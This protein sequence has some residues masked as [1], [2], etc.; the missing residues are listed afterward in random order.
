MILNPAGIV[1]GSGKVGSMRPEEVFP[2][3]ALQGFKPRAEELSEFLARHPGHLEALGARLE[4]Q[5]RRGFLELP[6]RPDQPRGE[7]Y[8]PH[9]EAFAQTLAALSEQPAWLDLPRVPMLLR[10][11]F[12]QRPRDGEAAS[13]VLLANLR[14]V[15]DR[16]RRSLVLDPNRKNLWRCWASIAAWNQWGD[17]E[18]L[19][20]GI[21]PCPGAMDPPIPHDSL[22][23]MLKEDRRWGIIET[24]AVQAFQRPEDSGHAEQ[25]HE[26]RE[27]LLRLVPPLFLSFRK[28]GRWE[29]LN[30]WIPLVRA[31]AGAHWGELR[32]ALPSGLR[33]PFE[34][35]VPLSV[36]AALDQPP[37]TL[38]PG[39]P[40]NEAPLEILFGE[41][42]WK[43]AMA[44]WA[45]PPLVYLKPGVVNWKRTQALPSFWILRDPG[46]PEVSFQGMDHPLEGLTKE[47]L[48]R[49]PPKVLAWKGFLKSHPGHRE[50]GRALYAALSARLPNPFLS[51][52]I[53]ALAADQE[54]PPP[55][56]EMIPEAP[57]I[58]TTARGQLAKLDSR[59]RLNPGGTAIWE[60]WWA[61][62]K[63]L[64]TPPP[65]LPLLEQ[66]PVWG[67]R[68][69]WIS[70]L[71]WA[72]W[73]EAAG[74]FRAQK[75]WEELG[76]WALARMA[77]GRFLDPKLTPE[78]DREAVLGFL[79]ASRREG[80]P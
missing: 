38:D 45:Q 63:L 37:L 61:W 10:M 1:K 23:V 49:R 55:G 34:P 18:E 60:A 48:N 56:P 77:S 20:A 24:F 54:L 76:E 70:T 32:Q 7:S 3:F 8:W 44:R 11:I 25:R 39:L 17:L 21:D 14:K 19:L 79:E 27:A 13:G 74:E 46:N 73:K 66:V 9:A 53:L 57:A 31:K 47:I 43:E 67:D 22:F 28:Q 75:R 4:G 62:R 58:E 29:Q 80:R 40:R 69:K 78:P 12:D 6:D 42:L 15:Q 71:P 35:E 36:R 33:I 50:A 51:D 2:E 59:L 52:E 26:V 64:V 65:V 68:P 30:T 72:V 5:I 16:I 41:D